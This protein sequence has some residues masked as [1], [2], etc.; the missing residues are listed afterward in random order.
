MF[1]VKNG[2]PTYQKVVTKTLREYLNNFMKVFLDDFIV[3]WIVI[4]SYLDYVFKSA[5]NMA[6]V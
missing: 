4:C 3:T 2:P 1:G 5:E 6:L